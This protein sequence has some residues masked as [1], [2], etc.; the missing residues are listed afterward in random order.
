MTAATT[1]TAT[2]AAPAATRARVGWGDLLWLTWRQHRW[3]VGGTAA[4]AAGLSAL[5]LGVAWHVDATG[6]VEHTLLFDEYGYLTVAQ[7]LAV[8]PVLAGFLIAVFWAA[9]LLSREYEQR[10]HLVVWTQD[11]SP[12]RWLAGKV[13]LLGAAGAALSAGFGAAVVV[14]MNSVNRHTDGGSEFLPFHSDAFE[15]V[16]HVQVGYALFG[17]ALGLALSALTRRTVLSM[18]LALVV[19][20]LV[21][22]LVASVWR[23]YYASPLRSVAPYDPL[24]ENG[25]NI[26]WPARDALMVDV[27]YLDAAGAEMDAVTDTSC[28]STADEAD[29]YGRCLFDQGVRQTFVDYQPV[30]RVLSFQLVELGIF[31]AFAAG[32][33]ALT[34]WWVKRTHRV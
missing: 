27:G 7:A 4:I 18:G 28:L 17:F 26:A 5:A 22:G 15:V 24:P 6:H 32:L 13:V 23:P 25:R 20:F 33:F 21:R 12:A 2:T 11:L 3:T 19:F 14:L 10:T 30:D 16:P 31:T 1:T 34:F 8:A 9:P 29:G